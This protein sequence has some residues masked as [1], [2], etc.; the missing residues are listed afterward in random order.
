MIHLKYY[1]FSCFLLI[2]GCISAQKALPDKQ[3]KKMVDGL[4][5]QMTLDEKLGQL[6]LVTPGYGIPTGSSVSTDVESKLKSGKIGGMFGISGL[7]NIKAAQDLVMKNT[8]LKIPLFFGS[9]VIH[10]YQTGFPVPLGL[11]FSW[12]MGLIEQSARVA[13]QEA[14]AHGINWTFSPMVDIARDPRWGRVAEGA[15]EDPYLGGL[16][17]AAMVRGYQGNDLSKNNTILACVKHFA[18]YGAAEGGRDYNTVD[19]SRLQMYETYLP[20]Y[21]AAIDAGAATVMSSF[22]VIDGVPATGNRWLLTDLLRKEWGFSGMVVSDYTSI[23]EMSNHGLGDLQTVSAM[24]L[25]AGLDMDMV[26][27]GFLNT[28]TKSL[29][30]GKITQ[31]EIDMACRRVLEAKYKL[32]LFAD[33]YRYID[34]KRPAIDLM[35]PAHRAASR[36]IAAHSMVLLKND[37]Q[38]LPLKEAS[39]QIV[40][41]IGPLAHDRSNMLGTWMISADP[42]KSVSVYEGMQ[43]ALNKGVA[44][45]KGANISDDTLFA[46][47]VNVFG[48]RIDVDARTPESMLQEA[49]EL[50][51]KSD[52]IVVVIG[53]ASEMTGESASRTSIQVPECQMVML[54]A[55]K[56]TGKKI[57]TIVMAGR[58]LIL[59]EVHQLSD[60]TLF[61]GHPGTEAG[62]AI[63]DV[64]LGKTIPS[65]K[66]TMTFPRNVGQIPIYYAALP[67]GRPQATD[68]F[69]KFQSNYLDSENSPFY[70]FGYGLSFTKF[71]Y[72]NLKLS[73]TKMAKT[74]TLTIS[75]QVRNTGAYDAE[76]V[77]QLYLRD[78]VASVSRPVKQLKG[79]QKVLIKKGETKQIEFQITEKD[80]RF[81]D[82]ALKHISEPG[83]HEVM[84]GTNSNDV[85]R[86]DFELLTQ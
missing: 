4:M 78:R 55:L 16:V 1:F 30:E 63:T 86:A 13:A 67:T 8:R 41:L 66:L 20:P 54:R 36:N 25:H 38:T 42:Q 40:A 34:A 49:L 60:A 51:K 76:E 11:S 84:V 82:Q 19:M 70:P 39:T 37:N 48:T 80:I 53:E 62:N 10:G 61:T 18:L 14:S 29:K 3:M 35:N 12:D 65:G 59:S 17:A 31:K 85:L 64:L 58:P 15:G 9:D 79:Y 45:A 52:I 43:T 44:Y 33:A 2:L 7:E 74:G 56:K 69:Q 47:K 46:K 71:A 57:V 23:N 26:G 50:A 72:S 73:T 81:Y 32:G 6:N 5:K 24:S 22:N 68:A 77:V 28:L 75:V 83:V 27:E 21:R